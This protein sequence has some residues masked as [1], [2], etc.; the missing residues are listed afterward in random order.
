MEA[1]FFGEDGAHANK[2]ECIT[3]AGLQNSSAKLLPKGTL[4]MAM[5]GQGVTRGK[6]AFLEIEAAT[7]QACAALF[8]DESLDSGYLSA[9]CTFAYHRIREL[10]HGANQ[11]NLSAD[12]IREILLPLPAGVEEQKEIY[13][14]LKAVES[15]L[16]IAECNHDT[17]KSLF[18]SMLHLLM[19]GQVRVNH[20]KIEKLEEW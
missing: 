5:Y 17:L 7:N 1:P 4:L 9:F 2:Q 14:V 16:R 13:H 8:P 6:V 19:T 11:K 15:R 18:S 3:E 20:L 12:I 10:G